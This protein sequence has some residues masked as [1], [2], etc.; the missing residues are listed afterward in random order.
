MLKHDHPE[1]YSD[2]FL[3]L[4][5]IGAMLEIGSSSS[6]QEH[7]TLTQFLKLNMNGKVIL[8]VHLPV[9]KGNYVFRTFKIGKRYQNATAYVNA[10]LL[11]EFD[12]DSL[13][14]K[15]RPRICYG[16]INP[17]FVSQIY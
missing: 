17:G 13:T 16:G 12:E 8:S 3:L 11:F 14:I 15:S 2:V 4:E 9:Y 1:F 7:Y 6:I 5:G 10:A